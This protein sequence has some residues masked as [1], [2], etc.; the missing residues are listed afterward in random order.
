MT[1]KNATIV[2]VLE[3]IAY[4][5]AQLLLAALAWAEAMLSG[6]FAWLAG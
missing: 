4:D 2:L 5:C 1:V 6:G 3:A